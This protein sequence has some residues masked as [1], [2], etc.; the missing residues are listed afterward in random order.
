MWLPMFR[1]TV[2][3]A[4][5]MP[6]RVDLEKIVYRTPDADKRWAFRDIETSR[7]SLGDWRR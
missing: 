7:P 4:I 6:W 5:A 1:N 2:P 3:K